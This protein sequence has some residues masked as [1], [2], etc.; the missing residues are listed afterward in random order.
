MS[1]FKSRKVI[2]VITDVIMKSSGEVVEVHASD[3]FTANDDDIKWVKM[4]FDASVDYM[5]QSSG[6][7]K[8]QWKDVTE[9]YVLALEP[10]LDQP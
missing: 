2:A 1:L 6:K 4:F 7:R 8:R 10:P 5:N 9:D 3:M